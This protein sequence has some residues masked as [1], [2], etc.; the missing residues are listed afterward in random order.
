MHYGLVVLCLIC[1]KSL[2]VFHI[3]RNVSVFHLINVLH[4]A[5]F[6]FG[7]YNAKPKFA[8]SIN[9]TGQTLFIHTNKSLRKFIGYSQDFSIYR[10][11]TKPLSGIALD[12]NDTEKTLEPFEVLRIGIKL[13]KLHKKCMES[14]YKRDPLGLFRHFSDYLE[15]ILVTCSKYT[16]EKIIDF[17]LNDSQIFSSD[18]GTTGDD[19]ETSWLANYVLNYLRHKIKVNESSNDP[20]TQDTFEN[21]SSKSK[22]LASWKR[23]PKWSSERNL[24]DTISIHIQHCPYLI[25]DLIKYSL[26][27]KVNLYL[28][29]MLSKTDALGIIPSLSLIHDFPRF[30]LTHH[31]Y[32]EAL[33]YIEKNLLS[34]KNVGKAYLPIIIDLEKTKDVYTLMKVYEHMTDV[35][36][37]KIS[38]FLITRLILTIKEYT[39][40]QL[41]SASPEDVSA[42]YSNMREQLKAVLKLYKDHKFSHFIPYGLARTICDEFNK[43]IPGLFHI[44]NVYSE[45]NNSNDMHTTHGICDVC[46]SKIP[47]VRLTDKERLLIFD[48]W[49]G[50]IYSSNKL[51][52]LGLAEFYKVLYEAIEAN[53]PYTCVLDG[54]NIG[55]SNGGTLLGLNPYLVETARLEMLSRG[56]KPLLVFPAFKEIYEERDDIQLSMLSFF[57]KNPEEF[58]S[59]RMIPQVSKNYLTFNLKWSKIFKQWHVADYVYTCSPMGYDDDYLFM[60]GIMTGSDEEFALIAKYLRD[61]LNV[62]SNNLN[63]D[64]ILRQPE[65]LPNI[66]DRHTNV[67]ILTNDTLSNLSIPGISKDIL[68]KWKKTCLRPYT[69][70]SKHSNAALGNFNKD[71]PKSRAVISSRQHY[72]LEINTC[73][74]YENWHIPLGLYQ[75]IEGRNRLFECKLIEPDDSKIQVILKESQEDINIA[76]NWLKTYGYADY[77]DNYTTTTTTTTNVSSQTEFIFYT[78]EPEVAYQRFT[79]SQ[80]T[81][82]L[83]INLE[84]VS[85]CVSN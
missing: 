74:D 42:I 17:E 82:W 51:E 12:K 20:S 5:S 25:G 59:L 3:A 43:V 63:S 32:K 41:S 77:S 83:C 54:Q 64:I 68:I 72:S 46:T 22:F 56:E 45:G 7:Y 14:L 55:F 50:S 2:F 29:E 9:L 71:F 70:S 65:H 81:C 4:F 16:S 44:S 23:A 24:Q 27:S 61:T 40:S 58:S 47:L 85:Q 79:E 31:G 1:F 33:N 30:Y 67:T 76:K 8:N 60:A 49:L 10:R 15:S 62:Y 19:C 13:S 36:T 39:K 26:V 35:S 80:K 57:F 52:I 69:F 18:K 21:V 75:A 48:K 38:W 6:H 84:A 11:C 53:D 34:E 37:A 66:S 28:R 73:P 78:H